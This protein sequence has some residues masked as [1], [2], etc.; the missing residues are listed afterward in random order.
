VG[1]QQWL[2]ILKLLYRG[3]RILIFDEPTSV[4]AA[5]QV[6]QL[7]KTIRRLTDER[8]SVVFISHKLR[9]MKAIADRVTVLRDGHVVGTVDPKETSPTEMA[10]MMVGRDVFLDRRPRQPSKA[11]PMLR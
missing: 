6:E 3:S 4:L 7:F 5:S 2:E 9:E 10:Q 8:Y 11:K 1:D